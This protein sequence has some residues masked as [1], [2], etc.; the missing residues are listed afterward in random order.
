MSL[1]IFSAVLPLVVMLWCR[2][3]FRLPSTLNLYVGKI[4]IVLLSLGA[5]LIGV[6][7][8]EPVLIS[9]KIPYFERTDPE[10]AK[11]HKGLVVNTLGVATDLALLAFATDTVPEN[12]ASFFFIAIASLESTGTLIGIAVLYPL[13]QIF[14][15]DK[16]LLGG[17]PYY[18]C[19]VCAN[20]S[21]LFDTSFL[22]HDRAC[23]WFALL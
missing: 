7:R 4:S 17:M 3:P 13:Y 14:L 21:I 20:A 15:D 5:I 18:V 16:T 6:A 1:V 8:T 2:S 22:I 19:G 11:H 10:E 23:S 9:G 12:I